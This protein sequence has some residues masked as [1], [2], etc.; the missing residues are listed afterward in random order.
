MIQKNEIYF[1]IDWFQSYMKLF[2]IQTG[3]YFTA[4]RH[5]SA[6]YPQTKNNS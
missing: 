4:T 1:R 3:K 6:D 5:N 2:N